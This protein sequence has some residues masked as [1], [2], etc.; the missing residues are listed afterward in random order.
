MAAFIGFE[1]SEREKRA[2]K[3][4]AVHA[5]VSISEFCRAL[6]NAALAGD[7]LVQ[8][9]LDFEEAKE[10]HGALERVSA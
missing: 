1:C 8:R 2:V 5:D 9:M 6:L 10:R 4:M 7:T 3:L